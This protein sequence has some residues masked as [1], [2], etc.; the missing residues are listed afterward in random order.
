[1]TLDAPFTINSLTVNDASGMT[2][3]AG[4]LLTINATGANGNT[5][6]NGITVNGGG[7]PRLDRRSI[8]VGR[9]PNLDEQ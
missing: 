1:M 5:A 7:R 4:N 2:L 8:G 6:G 3:G 9:C